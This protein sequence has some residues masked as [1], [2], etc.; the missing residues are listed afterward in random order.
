MEEF[1]D[2]EGTGGVSPS[3]SDDADDAESKG[4]AEDAD[5]DAGSQRGGGG[6][7]KASKSS[8]ASRASRASAGVS[9]VKAR[10][11]CDDLLSVDCHLETKELWDKFHELGTEMIITKTGR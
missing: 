10:C 4:D 3:L 11:N 6:N 9:Q 8:K 7:R 5:D 2:A 1:S